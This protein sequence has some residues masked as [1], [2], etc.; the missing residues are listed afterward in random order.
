M[1]RFRGSDKLTARL[2][3]TLEAQGATVVLARSGH[4]KIYDRNGVLLTT[5][6]ATSSDWRATRNLRALLRRKGLTL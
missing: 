1:A 3:R 4:W 2:I 5:M 6:A